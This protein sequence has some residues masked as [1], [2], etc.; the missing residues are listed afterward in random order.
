MTLDPVLTQSQYQFLQ[1]GV[2]I[3][4]RREFT[5][6]QLAAY[7]FRLTVTAAYGTVIGVY[8][9]VSIAALEDFASPHR[10]PDSHASTLID[11][12]TQDDLECADK[13][14]KFSPIPQ[15]S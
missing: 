9:G 15:E 13:F 8:Y 10:N 7:R 6:E 1:R 5:P 11:D 12:L 14:G 4:T 3:S 2:S